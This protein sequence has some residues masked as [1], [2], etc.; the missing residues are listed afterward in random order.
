[1]E[2]KQIGTFLKLL[3]KEK[4]I[5]QEQL[6]QTLNVSNRTVSRWETGVNL[7]DISLIV[8]LSKFYN[9]SINE[10]IDGKRCDDKVDEENK[11]NEIKII[12]YSKNEILINK[13]KITSTIICILGMLII[14]SALAI[15]PN[16]SSWGSVYSIL[17]GI[18]LTFGVYLRTKLISTKI[19]Y[20]LCCVLSC[21]AVLFSLFLA[22][23]YICV[24]EFNQVPRF[25]YMKIYSGESD[26]DTIEHKTLFYSVIQ[27]NPG[28][29]YEKIKIIHK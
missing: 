10:I 27:E 28:T 9:I 16:E 4:N 11:K 6:A 13:R 26:C 14:V 18:I 12:E 29:S 21:I 17:G 20:Q 22:F 3:R 24:S 15:F 1:M 7:P 19:T 25:S 23:D 8:E 5:T 2:Q